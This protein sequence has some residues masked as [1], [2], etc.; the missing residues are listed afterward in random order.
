MCIRDSSYMTRGEIINQWIVW[1][2]ETIMSDVTLET[3]Y[4]ANVH[5]A[6]QCQERHIVFFLHEKQERKKRTRTA[7]VSRLAGLS[8][9][10]RHWASERANS[11]QANRE[12]SKPTFL[13][14]TNNQYSHQPT[15]KYQSTKQTHKETNLPTTY[16]GKSTKHAKHF[17]SPILTATKCIVS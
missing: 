13:V 8:Y 4:T 7:V 2:G 12:T 11:G 9:R 5:W 16:T 10:A 14:N 17:R 3:W 1:F 15:N 6:N